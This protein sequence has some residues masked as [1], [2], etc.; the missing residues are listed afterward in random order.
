VIAACRLCHAAI[1]SAFDGTG[2]VR[3]TGKAGGRCAATIAG[4][5]VISAIVAWISRI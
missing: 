1:V 3:S 2:R 4:A 5:N